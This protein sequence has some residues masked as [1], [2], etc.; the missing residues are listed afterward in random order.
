[1]ASLSDILNSPLSPPP[2]GVESNFVDPKS[3]GYVLI[4]IDSICLVLMVCF[5]AIRVYAKGFVARKVAWDDCK[6]TYIKLS[7]AGS[8]VHSDFRDWICKSLQWSSS[9]IES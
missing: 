2:D 6:L 1:M 9:L 8:N 4:V 3:D 7:A 5:T